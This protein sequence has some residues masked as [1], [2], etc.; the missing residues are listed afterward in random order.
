M[1]PSAGVWDVI[2]VG[3]GPGGAV[4]AREA[5]RLGLGAVLLLDRAAFP[6]PKTCGGGLSPRARVTLERLG[7]WERVRPGAYPISGLRLVGP[8]GRAVTLGGREAAWV[9]D[10]ERLDGRLVE[11]AT[12]VGV[13]FEPGVR[14]TGLL[15]EGGRVAGVR[16]GRAADG[17]G[18]SIEAR[19]VILA[20]GVHGLDHAVPRLQTCVA[21][22]E[23][24]PITPHHVEMVYDRALLP[25]YG[26]LFPEGPDRVNIGLCVADEARAGRSVRDLLAA[27]IE[28]HFA[29]RLRA[30][31]PL[32][33]W[34]GHPIPFARRVAPPQRPGALVVGDAAGLVNP[35][36]GEGI[37]YAV[38]SGAFAARA[39]VRHRDDAAAAG[40]EYGR[41]VRRAFEWRFRLATAYLAVCG[42]AIDALTGLAGGLP[43]VG[44][45][46]RDALAR[47]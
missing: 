13:R 8:R 10:R 39:L 21:R 37:A 47:L 15:V 3:A 1:L 26:W 27:L 7:L 11:A 19:R 22:F 38:A 34:R 14:V 9:L 46:A 41:A 31:R 23:G 36:T 28:R 24:V 12:D 4:A 33:P 25:H 29:A 20:D 2:V 42:P 18:G 6:R 32:G 45:A 35:A 16:T 17:A 44:R 43:L 5:A 40:A 30:A